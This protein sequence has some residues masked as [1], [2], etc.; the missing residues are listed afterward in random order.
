MFLTK[1]AAGPHAGGRHVVNLA[2][3]GGQNGRQ[4]GR[5]DGVRLTS[6]GESFALAALCFI[7][8]Y[9]VGAV[10]CRPWQSPTLKEPTR[11]VARGF[12]GTTLRGDASLTS[13]RPID[14]V[15]GNG[16]A[17]AGVKPSDGSALTENGWCFSCHLIFDEGQQNTLHIRHA[18]DLYDEIAG[19]IIG[20]IF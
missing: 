16:G 4:H 9:C 7:G 5:I 20:P 11:P 6:A 15:D 3:H 2:Q 13:I 19:D 17:E 12:A 14:P 8:A 10:D 18:N 1:F